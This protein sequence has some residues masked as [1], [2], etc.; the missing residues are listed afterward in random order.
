MMK[1]SFSAILLSLALL[2]FL[3]PVLGT[4]AQAESVSNVQY[5]DR[6]WSG[7]TVVSERKTAE[8]C[9]VIDENT[10]SLNSG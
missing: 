5:V 8:K 10:E 1:K 4:T 7:S 9:E 6:S 2:L 3:A